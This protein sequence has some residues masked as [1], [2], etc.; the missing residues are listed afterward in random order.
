MS[1]QR[2]R[3]LVFELN[4]FNLGLLSKAAE[5]LSLTH[6]QRMLAMKRTQLRTQDRYESD[7]LEPWV[8]WVSVHTGTPSTVHKIK[9]LGDVPHL[10]TPQVWAE[11]S[12]HHITSGVW[13]AM[14][15]GRANA[16]SCLF[17]L[18]DPWTFSEDGYPQ[19][20]SRLLDLPRYVSK[21]YLNLSKSTVA[22]KF[23]GFLSAFLFSK[24]GFS[25]L[26]ELPSFLWNTLK[27]KGE[28]FVFICFTEY[29]SSL[30][31]LEY[32]K[33]H[34]PDL[35]LLFVNS[36]AHLQHH[37]WHSDSYKDNARLGY[38]LKM[39][40]RLLGKIFKALKEGE[41][42][43]ALNGLSQMNTN[44]E[45]PWILYRQRDQLS[46]LRRVGVSYTHVE[47]HMTHDA[48]IFF[49]SPEGCQRAKAILG[50]ATVNQEKLFL[51]EAYADDPKKL[52]Y[53]IQ[54]T[55]ELP[56]DA[57]LEVGGKRERFFDL[58]EAIVRR[59]GKHI[60][61]GTLFTNSLEVPDSMENHELYEHVLGFYGVS[62]D[63]PQP[64]LKESA[65][66]TRL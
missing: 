14:N 2:R 37:H 53:R 23:Y 65:E 27:F 54:F 48:H 44:H 47:P 10:H 55:D 46:F 62:R 34:D 8:Q 4:E 16:E 49:A 22:K 1:Q 30:L 24:V 12:K 36:L 45:K 26:A 9:H 40:D 32:K 41:V 19:S 18:P 64:R 6:V 38:G 60:P 20:L 57:V 43:V 21:N 25:F 15:A 52:F 17:F 42:F 13:G 5:E 61:V 56:H 3:M 35:S 59:T 58:F 63:R 11:L 28:H 51:V 33:R 31:F 29:L 50:S 66:S 7:Y 39:I